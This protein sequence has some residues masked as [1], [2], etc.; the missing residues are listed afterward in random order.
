[1]SQRLDPDALARLEAERDFLLR[2][3]D[4][5]DAELSVGD[6]DEVDHAE[7]RDDY[8]RRAAEV[9]RAIEE[10]RQAFA[11]A[12]H[13]LTSTQRI[14]SFVGVIAIAA[15][16]GVLLARAVG[17]RSPAGELSGGIRQTTAGLLNEADTLTREGRWDDAFSIYEQ[18]LDQEPSNAEALTYSGWIAFTQ[19]GEPQLGL[20]RIADAVATDAQYPDARVFSALTARRQ[21]RWNDAVIAVEA[22]DE[23]E[24]KPAEMSMLVEAGNLRGQIVAGLMSDQ[25]EET[26]EIDLDALPFGIDA[27]A[28]GAAL[29][30]SQEQI[31]AALAAFDA[32][33]DVEPDNR[34]ALIGMGRRLATTSPETAERGLG[35]LDQA[36]ANDPEDFEALVWRGFSRAVAG[37]TD[38]A[39]ADLDLLDASDVPPELVEFVE[40]LR[41]GLTSS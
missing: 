20:D 29:L 37:D 39:Q 35:L 25:Y 18:V 4:D 3:L 15:I 17:F 16:A 32:V 13:G 28:S 23:I 2:S 14:L 30:D 21:E 34:V 26:D 12:R 27:A 41:A 40:G 10:Q 31:V 9:L 7:L 33:L 24:D 5:L 38:G 11:D 8:T 19:L 6:I 36:V 22:F 1:M